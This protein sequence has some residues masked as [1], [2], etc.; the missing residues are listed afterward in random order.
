MVTRLIHLYKEKQ[1]I[2]PQARGAVR[3]TLG[4]EAQFRDLYARFARVEAMSLDRR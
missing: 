4:I 3:T 1:T 2:H